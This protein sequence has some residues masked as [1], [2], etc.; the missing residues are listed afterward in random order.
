L[1]EDEEDLNDSDYTYN[2]NGSK[3]VRK[4]AKKQMRKGKDLGKREEGS[5]DQDGDQKVETGSKGDKSS[6]GFRKLSY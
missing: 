4:R 3:R 6:T 5:G 1:N 2:I